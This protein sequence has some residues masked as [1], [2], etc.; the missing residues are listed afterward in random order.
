LI[1]KTTMQRVSGFWEGG[2]NTVAGLVRTLV[3]LEIWWDLFIE[4]NLPLHLDILPSH[5]TRHTAA[6]PTRIE[7]A[8]SHGSIT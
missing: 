1:P 6:H 5:G 3:N 7:R 2:N 4:G 8:L